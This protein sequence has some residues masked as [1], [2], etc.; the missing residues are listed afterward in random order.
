MQ[1]IKRVDIAPCQKELKVEVPRQKVEEEFNQVYQELKKTASVP[2]FRVGQAPRD[3]LERYHGKAAREE[4]LRRLVGR[5]LDEALGAQKDLDLIGNPVVTEVRLDAQQ[6]LTYSA[7]VEVAPAVSLGRYK[8]LKLTRSKVTVSP[9]SLN[10]ALTRLQETQAQLV[11]LLEPRSAV[12]GDF[13]LVDITE[14]QAGLPAGQ[15]GKAPV[16]NS[17]RLIHLDAKHNPEQVV[18]GLI[19]IAPGQQ[20]T[21]AFES[22]VTLTVDCS[23]IKVK[24]LPP[25]DDSFAKTV[26]PFDSLESLR[27]TLRRDLAKQAEAQQQRALQAQIAETLLA[28]WSFDCPP[29]LVASWA[30]RLLKERTLELLGQGVSPSQVEERSQLMSEQAKLD[31][32]KQVRIFFILRKI[33][34]AEGISVTEEELKDK[35]AA[36]G[37][38]MQITPEELR[39]NLEEKELLD[40]LTWSI[41]RGKVFEWILKEAEIRD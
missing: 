31:A 26:G 8:G 16:K 37:Q 40:E 41:T 32:V 11:P 39:K 12:E 7:R 10:Q 22:G 19:G 4:V 21:I 18:K 5:S 17:Q 2:G 36:L 24:Q 34:Q 25:L 35:L 15:A 28:E 29:T 33:A 13:L 27:E 3:L 14:N 20:R 30:K 1:I 9:E 6:P 38:S 23:Q